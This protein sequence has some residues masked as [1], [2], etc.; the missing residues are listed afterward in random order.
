MSGQSI[1]PVLALI[2]DPPRGR[3]EDQQRVHRNTY[4]S[5]LANLDASTVPSRVQG[6]LGEIGGVDMHTTSSMGYS[7]RVSEPKSPILPSTMDNRLTLLQA[8]SLLSR[9]LP[10]ETI[11]SSIE[12]VDQQD[13]L[14]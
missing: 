3:S 10:A 9:H 4:N 14:R 5:F 7:E 13:F 8:Q 6:V 12:R 1:A 2:Y 11:L